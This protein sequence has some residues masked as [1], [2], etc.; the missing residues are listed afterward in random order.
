MY[1]GARTVSSDTTH[2]LLPIDGVSEHVVPCFDITYLSDVASRL[3]PLVM[4]ANAKYCGWNMFYNDDGIRK[5]SLRLTNELIQTINSMRINN[6]AVQHLFAL[7][8]QDVMIAKHDPGWMIGHE[9]NRITDQFVMVK[10]GNKFISLE[11][12]IIAVTCVQTNPTHDYNTNEP[13]DR[14]LPSIRTARQQVLEPSIYVALH[15]TTIRSKLSGKRWF[16]VIYIVPHW[17][18]EVVNRLGSCFVGNNIVEADIMKSILDTLRVMTAVGVPSD[19]I[20]LASRGTARFAFDLMLLHT[21]G[22]CSGQTKRR[23]WDYFEY[24]NY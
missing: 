16:D 12:Q 21:Q 8:T 11:T 7:H 9:T 14:R 23:V 6:S 24:P 19:S 3:A 15:T 22:L 1:I 10:S 20:P 18:N 2:P 4:R 17:V 13:P 5:A